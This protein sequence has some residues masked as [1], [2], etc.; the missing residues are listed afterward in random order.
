[1]ETIAQQQYAAGHG[2]TEAQNN[3]QSNS[4]TVPAVVSVIVIVVI[5]VIVI[6]LI[7]TL[8]SE[9]THE[10]FFIIVNIISLICLK[11][12]IS[13]LQVHCRT[14]LHEMLI[15]FKGHFQKD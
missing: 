3:K 15:D 10:C 2:T 9:Y 11:S 8:Y 1:M 13:T 5:V 14:Q 12:R 4:A 7:L 6:I